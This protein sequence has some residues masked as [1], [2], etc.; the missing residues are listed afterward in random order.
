MSH[1]IVYHN[2]YWIMP[3][4]LKYDAGI[5]LKR[6]LYTGISIWVYQWNPFIPSVIRA[7]QKAIIIYQY[8]AI[9]LNYDT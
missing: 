7:M 4:H 1:G 2:N 8:L 3:V 5:E 9:G 6:T